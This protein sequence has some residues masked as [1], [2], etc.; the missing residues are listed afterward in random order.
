M[1]AV[2]KS[3]REHEEHFSLSV[4]FQERGRHRNC[5]AFVCVDHLESAPAVFEAC[6]YLFIFL[7]MCIFSPNVRACFLHV[8]PLKGIVICLEKGYVV[9]VCVCSYSMG[10]QAKV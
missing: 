5:V 6:N 7:A 2:R 8:F 10:S 4:L 9:C 3:I 1:W